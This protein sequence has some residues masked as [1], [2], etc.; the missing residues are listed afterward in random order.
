VP[1]PN[2]P[3]APNTGSTPLASQGNRALRSGPIVYLFPAR[4]QPPPL[5]TISKKK[6][7]PEW[8][9]G[10]V[11]FVHVSEVYQ[12]CTVTIPSAIGSTPGTWR[13][14]LTLMPRDFG[15][16]YSPTDQSY[17][18]RASAGRRKS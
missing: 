13:S 9:G 10:D 2:T 1:T 15:T 3:V 18:P 11:Q 5:S 12:G 16:A 6:G 7:V 8:W 17:L 14:E 4:P